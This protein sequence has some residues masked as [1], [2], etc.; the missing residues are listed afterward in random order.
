MARNKNKFRAED[1]LFSGE[2]LGQMGYDP[3]SP[4]PPRD[5]PEY[6]ENIEVD[7][8]CPRCAYRWSSGGEDS[9]VPS[10]ES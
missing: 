8:C 2:E 3:N 6:D 5:W 9:D 10:D 1:A 7:R 4:F